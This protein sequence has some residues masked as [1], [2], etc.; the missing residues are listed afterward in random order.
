MYTSTEMFPFLVLLKWIRIDYSFQN[1]GSTNKMTDLIGV[2]IVCGL[3]QQYDMLVYS[4][5]IFDVDEKRRDVQ[6]IS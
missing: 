6:Q 5:V 3:R 4:Y 2:S 1:S